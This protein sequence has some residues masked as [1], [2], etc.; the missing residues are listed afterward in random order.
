[1]P[2]T[3]CILPEQNL[4]RQTMWGTV[5]AKALRDMTI[6]MRDDPQFRKGLD[7]LAD[8][9]RARV[10]ISYDEML[11][12]ATFLGR[13]GVI[14]RQAIVVS[15]QLEFG[16]ARMFEQLT[17]LSVRR[18]DLKV[19]LDMEAAERWLGSPAAQGAN[20]PGLS[21]SKR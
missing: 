16:M 4:V 21:S 15:G 2:F 1:M 14:G 3:C 8:F 17:E 6:A 18:T 19:F 10:D 12:F 13:H 20:L 5:N 7:I 9:R 11:E